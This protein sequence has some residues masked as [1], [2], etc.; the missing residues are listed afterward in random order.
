[1]DFDFPVDGE[2]FSR[3]YYLVEGIYLQLSCFLSSESNPHTK[4]AF[5]FAEDKEAHRK[6]V[7]RGFGLPKLRFLALLHPISLHDCNNIY[8]VVPALILMH[9]MMVEACL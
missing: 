4:L 9:D 3:L 6:D 2:V 5:S 8:Y 1:L 7:E